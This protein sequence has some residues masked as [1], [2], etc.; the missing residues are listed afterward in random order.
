MCKN[1]T[2]KE[3]IRITPSGIRYDESYNRRIEE[4]NNRYSSNMSTKNNSQATSASIT[5]ANS[6]EDVFVINI[7]YNNYMLEKESQK[8]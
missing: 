1:K 7:L 5:R 2:Y 6:Q 4:Y 3:F 8:I